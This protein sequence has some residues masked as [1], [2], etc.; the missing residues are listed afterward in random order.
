MTSEPTRPQLSQRTV[1]VNAASTAT[2]PDGSSWTS[3]FKGLQQALATD[4]AEIWVAA[5]TY[6]PGTTAD[7]TF[8][9]NQAF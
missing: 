5:G 1:H 8:Q 9:L 6:S 7:A 4:A 2:Q 3:A